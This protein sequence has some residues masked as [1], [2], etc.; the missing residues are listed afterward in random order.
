MRTS[1][2]VLLCIVVAA[3]FA[4]G[5]G[6]AGR[7]EPAVVNIVFG[8]P[9]FSSGEDMPDDYTCEGMGI[10]PPLGWRELPEGTISLAIIMEDPRAA[11]GEGFVHWL[12]YNVPHQAGSVSRAIAP[13]RDLPG[14]AHQ[15]R[16]TS[17]SIGYTCPSPPKGEVH[18]YHFRLYALDVVLDLPGGA[19]KE[20]LLAAMEGHV[21]GR[22]EF[23]G[24]CRR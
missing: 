23:V 19:N 15:G 24:T 17:G 14:G 2:L 10:S 18:R 5:C 22:G 3:L 7:E 13:I 1:F 12:L 4:G 11:D 6:E 21:L 8:S 16:G 20:Q 9:D